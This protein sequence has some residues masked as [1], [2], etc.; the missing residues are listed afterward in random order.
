MIQMKNIKKLLEIVRKSSKRYGFLSGLQLF[1]IASLGFLYRSRC[2]MRYL[3]FRINT[4][5]PRLLLALINEIFV[6]EEYFLAAS[7]VGK[8]NPLI[9]DAGSNIGVSL[10][11]WKYYFADPRIV[12]FEPAPSLV[13]L[14]RNNVENNQINALVE[15]VALGESEGVVNFFKDDNHLTTGSTDKSRGG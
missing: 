2:T 15:E 11:Y 14:C 3:G 10:L 7:Q 13:E 9:I 6:K 12:A 4:P 8:G 5:N 1:H